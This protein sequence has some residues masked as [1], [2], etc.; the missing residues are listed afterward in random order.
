MNISIAMTGKV[1]TVILL[2][3]CLLKMPYGYYEFVRL[4]TT[5]MFSH[6]LFQKLNKKS[7]VA[8]NTFLIVWVIIM[9][10]PIFKI[11]LQREY[12]QIIDVLVAISLI[13][14]LFRERSN[15]T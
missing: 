11:S 14:S 15:A 9:F 2:F 5:T 1:I 7:N 13:V 10:Q 3:G 12:W 4:V 6:L 8:F